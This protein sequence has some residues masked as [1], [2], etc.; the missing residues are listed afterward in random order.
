LECAGLDG[1]LAP[2]LQLFPDYT[3]FYDR[4]ED[5]S[6]AKSR[7]RFVCGNPPDSPHRAGVA[8]ILWHGG[9]HQLS[10]LS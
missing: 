3:I 4:R 6:R 5:K 2:G 9:D 1:A 7:K 8:L 10:G